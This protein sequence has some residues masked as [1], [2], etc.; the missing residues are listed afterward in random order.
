MGYRSWDPEHWKI[1]RSNDVIFDEACMFK[2]PVVPQEPTRV[3][4]DDI[5]HFVQQPV[6]ANE[7][8][9]QQIRPNDDVAVGPNG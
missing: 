5:D 2:E 9:H 3:I 7:P 4:C 8:V 1:I 6:V